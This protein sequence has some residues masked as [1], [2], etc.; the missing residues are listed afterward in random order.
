MKKI[1]VWFCSA[2]LAALWTVPAFAWGAPETP[3]YSGSNTGLTVSRGMS[4]GILLVIIASSIMMVVSL[5]T[6][7][8]TY[9]TYSRMSE[10]KKEAL[11]EKEH[12]KKKAK[13]EKFAA[14][15]G[16]D[17]EDETDEEAETDE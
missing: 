5:V 12:E 2:F 16:S 11:E 7:I 10:D 9:K 13:K 4:I 14:S 17:A 8:M 3:A 1:A 15:Q 6:V